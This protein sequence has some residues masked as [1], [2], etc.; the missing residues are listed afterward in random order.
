MV[1]GWILK[2]GFGEFCGLIKE[3][4]SGL[5]GMGLPR[6]GGMVWRELDLAL[7]GRFL[8]G[9]SG[10]IGGL[11]LDM[12]ASPDTFGNGLE[13]LNWSLLEVA[14]TELKGLSIAGGEGCKTELEVS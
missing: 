13:I 1:L 10:H 7:V 9:S 12:G 5:Q 3:A 6:I 8:R 14:E 4:G 11:E 2:A